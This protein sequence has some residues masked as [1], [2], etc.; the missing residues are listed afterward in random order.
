MIKGIVGRVDLN[1]SLWLEDRKKKF[2]FNLSH[3]D[4]FSQILKEGVEKSEVKIQMPHFS[5]V[6][7][8]HDSLQLN[9]KDSCRPFLYREETSVLSKDTHSSS[10]L[11]SSIDPV[12]NISESAVAQSCEREESYILERFSIS[13]SAEKV[14]SGDNSVPCCPTQGWIG[15][16]SVSGLNLTISLSEIQ[17]KC[18]SFSLDLLKVDAFDNITNCNLFL[19]F[20]LVLLP[21]N[22]AD[23]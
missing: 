2:F 5:S 9:H 15:N 11:A 4:I 16:G 10:S 23:V 14:I 12:A 22:I 1:L 6:G 21:S 18:L 8:S 7:S 19:D 13:V 20:P 3:L 17:V